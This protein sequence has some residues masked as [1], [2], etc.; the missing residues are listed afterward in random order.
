MRMNGSVVSVGRDDRHGFSK[1]P[2][3]SVRLVAGFGIEGD[4]HA[5]VTTRH[6][7][8]VKKD[9]GRPNLTQVHLIGSEL[10]EEL[11]SSGFTVSPGG[12]G[13][14][15]TTQGL[16]LLTLPLGTL[17]HLGEDAV[18]EVTG[19]R[20]PC[21]LINKYQAGLLKAV[22]TKDADGQVIRKTG[23]MGVVAESGVVRPGDR[24]RV[25]LPTGEHLPLGVV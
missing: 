7:Y 18:V 15:I 4:V 25:E 1:P 16:D 10:F 14:N 13:E 6:R 17:L 20:S 2:T 24:I 22:L 12:L 19:L 9:P 23:I 8:L 5:G 11:A 21:H 3:E